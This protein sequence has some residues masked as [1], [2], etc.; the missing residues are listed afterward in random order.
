MFENIEQL[1]TMGLAALI[2]AFGTWLRG[3]LK[4]KWGK[5]YNHIIDMSVDAAEVWAKKQAAEQVQ[6][7][8]KEKLA[9][10]VKYAQDELKGAPKEIKATDSLMVAIEGAIAL[11]KRKETKTDLVNDVT[12][13]I[14][15]N[16]FE[17]RSE[18][19]E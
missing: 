1:I 9:Y 12:Q 8:A 10:A 6:R 15:K 4:S 13:I 2:L 14:K 5:K 16:H 7:E 3:Y 17:H 18:D 11:N 19:A